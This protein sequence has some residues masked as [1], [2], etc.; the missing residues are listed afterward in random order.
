VEEQGQSTV[1]TRSLAEFSDDQLL[2]ELA[3]RRLELRLQLER[4]GYGS[5]ALLLSLLGAV[6]SL[7]LLGG[8]LVVAFVPAV[9]ASKI[10]STLAAFLSV[11]FAAASYVAVKRAN[12]E[13]ERARLRASAWRQWKFLDKTAAEIETESRSQ[14]PTGGAGQ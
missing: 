13:L 5:S 14:S 3:A 11:A 8:S 4:V 6:M 7:A 2:A 10:L 1:P 12:T 9:A